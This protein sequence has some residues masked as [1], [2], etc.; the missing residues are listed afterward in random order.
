MNSPVAVFVV[1]LVAVLHIQVASSLP[2]ARI[3]SRS[4][5]TCGV[6]PDVT[7]F[8]QN[9]QLGCE[10]L[11]GSASIREHANDEHHHQRHHKKQLQQHIVDI[12]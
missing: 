6:V 10:S 2:S 11:C 5:I 4:L 1:V 3:A 9:Y 12:A 8:C 7:A